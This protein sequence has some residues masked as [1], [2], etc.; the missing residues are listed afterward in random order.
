M[1][2]FIESIKLLD[3]VF[4]RI[5]YHQKRVNDT[6]AF[7]FA[8]HK[9]H[10]LEAIWTQSIIPASGMYKCR[11]QYDADSVHVEFIP[12][13]LRKLESLRLIHTSIE[14]SIFK[15][16]SREAYNEAFEGRGDC[17]DVLLIH[18]GL[19]TDT[20]YCN[21]ALWDGQQW[22]SPQTPLLK[23]TNL[24]QLIDSG[25]VH[26]KD[27]SYQELPNYSKITLFNAMIEFGEI[28]LNT[29]QIKTN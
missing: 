28:T 23:G 2:Q 11:L 4:S 5:P 25:L 7:H 15:S 22:F 17:D 29:N 1:C 14:P 10:S 3:G 19:L 13:T 16:A 27:I 24:S 26:Q 8:G 6:F 20:S 21:I 18:K 12:Y 9:V